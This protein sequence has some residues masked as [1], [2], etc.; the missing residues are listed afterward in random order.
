MF[1]V[2]CR[3]IAVVYLHCLY[4]RVVRQ[5]IMKYLWRSHQSCHVY[6]YYYYY[7]FSPEVSTDVETLL[8][9]L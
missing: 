1:Y 3:L 9:N 5:N 4:L 7:S 2:I 6:Y 8:L